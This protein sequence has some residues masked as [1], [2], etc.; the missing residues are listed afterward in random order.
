[1]RPP[2]SFPDHQTER[3]PV[4]L[5]DKERL[6]VA[7]ARF[8]ELHALDEAKKEDEREKKQTDAASHRAELSSAV[9]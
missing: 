8:Y 3:W 6:Q 9:Y 7:V 2:L 5:N 4:M 1:R